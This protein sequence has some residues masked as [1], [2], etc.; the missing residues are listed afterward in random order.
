MLA[1]IGIFGLGTMGEN[2]CLNLIEKGF[3]VTVYNRTEEKTRAFYEKNK[4]SLI[5]PT[6]NLRD[7]VISIKK[8]RKIFL[9]IKAGK[10]V[11][12][13]INY[14]LN[15]V[16]KNDIIID[17]GNSHFKDSDRRYN[18]LKNLGLNFFGLGISGGIEGAR[19][20]LSIMVGGSKEAYEEIKDIIEKISAKY[21]SQ[22]CYAY[23]GEG[24]AGHFVKIVHNGIEYAL[25]ESIAEIFFLL[26]KFFDYEKISEI[27]EEWNKGILSSFLLSATI[28]ILRKKENGK[29]LL[30][31]ILDKAEQKGTGKWSVEI[32]LE[33]GIPCPAIAAAV[34]SRYVSMLKEDR[35]KYSKLYNLFNKIKNNLNL[36]DLKNALILS[37]LLSYIQGIYLLKGSIFYNYHINI[38]EALRIWRGGSIIR[39]EILNM[40]YKEYLKNEDILASDNIKSIILKNLNSLSNTLSFATSN[41]LP[42]NVISSNYNYL[43]MFISE[44]LSAN[45]TQALR[46]YFGAHGYQRI[47]KEGYFHTDWF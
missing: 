7:F 40:L 9:L 10:P 5:I 39:G 37:I 36:E 2:I 43:I 31:Y 26:S 45:L 21:E 11:D 23:F 32:S 28:N 44:K 42:V 1:D 27:F 47:D 29:F 14:L 17:A 24:G 18:E 13:A 38:S 20:G 41:N 34:F 4:S 12:E 16:E 33:T 19:K 15:Y 35:V 25:I 6:Y 8:P 30:D 22:P 46:D 3:S